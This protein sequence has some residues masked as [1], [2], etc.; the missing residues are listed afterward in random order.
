M[1]KERDDDNKSDIMI[2]YLFIWEKIKS[3]D[4]IVDDD[5]NKLW[6]NCGKKIVKE[7]CFFLNERFLQDGW[8]W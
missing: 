7:R 3:N 8:W 2:I 4:Q 1:E 6:W 5:D